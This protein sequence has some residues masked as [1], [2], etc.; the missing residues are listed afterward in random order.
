MLEEK[1]RR[2]FLRKLR[3]PGLDNLGRQRICKSLNELCKKSVYCPHCKSSNGTVKKIGPLK[4]THERYR[5]K[6]L[7]DELDAFKSSFQSAI[8]HVPELGQHVSKAQDDLHPLR[9]LHLF[10]NISDEDVELLGMDPK[11]GRPEHYIWTYFPVPPAGIRPSVVQD[12]Q[13]R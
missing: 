13:T 2:V 10:L 11:F 1:D 6:K 12:S 4:I 5:S 3:A 8:S 7:K 9:V